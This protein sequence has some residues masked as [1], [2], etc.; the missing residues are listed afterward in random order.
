ME[1]EGGVQDCI[2]YCQRH[3]IPEGESNPEHVHP[4]IMGQLLALWK[5]DM[6]KKYKHLEWSKRYLRNRQLHLIR[7]QEKRRAEE[8]RSPLSYLHRQCV[9]KVWWTLHGAIVPKRQCKTILPSSR[10]NA[11]RQFGFLW[12]APSAII[13]PSLQDTAEEQAA[14]P[15][16]SVGREQLQSAV[17][18]RRLMKKPA[19]AAAPA[20]GPAA[21]SAS[22]VEL[23]DL[24]LAQRVRRPPATKQAAPAK[25]KAAAPEAGGLS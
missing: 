24:P 3:S 9:V 8:V 10:G 16:A 7:L 11:A 5:L 19:E 18:R 13:H 23:E 6:A 4:P 17:K 15:T 21:V 20:S 2:L 1:P 12:R 22:G 14:S 25:R